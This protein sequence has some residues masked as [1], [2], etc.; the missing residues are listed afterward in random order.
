[1]YHRLRFFWVGLV[2]LSLISCGNDGELGAL[3][4]Q[5]ETIKRKPQGSV[6]PPPVFK[7]YEGF[8]YGAAFLRSP[9]APPVSKDAA[10]R[11]AGIKN[12]GL[13]PNPNRAKEPLEAFDLNALTMVGSLKRGNKRLYGLVADSEGNV[14]RVQEGSYLGR[15]DGRVIKITEAQIDFVELVSDSTGGW[16][17][18]PKS[19]TLTEK[20]E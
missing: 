8:T 18:S 9:F 4:A 12:N 6:Q 7:S 20:S 11:A 15:S 10:N 17:E 5:L 13:H 2:A 14:Y 3:K 19:L 16:V 1:M